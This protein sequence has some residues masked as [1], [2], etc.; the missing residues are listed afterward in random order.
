MLSAILLAIVGATS[1]QLGAGAE[2][3][4]HHGHHAVHIWST[5]YYVPV[6]QPYVYTTAFTD[7]LAASPGQ[8]VRLCV[9]SDHDHAG[10]L[11]VYSARFVEP[12]V[13][14]HGR[15]L[16]TRCAAVTI[17][18]RALARPGA[19]N[20]EE[21]TYVSTDTRLPVDGW[22]RNVSIRPAT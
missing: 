22:V 21:G 19:V 12:V 20:V 2:L 9:R 6:A 16:K 15:R 1:L 14:P 11:Y 7:L 17:T 18:S 13:M 3:V 5:D 4:T 8:Q 10:N